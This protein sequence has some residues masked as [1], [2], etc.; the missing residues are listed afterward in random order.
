MSLSHFR[1]CHQEVYILD[2]EFFIIAMST[3]DTRWMNMLALPR[4]VRI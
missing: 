4:L 2:P 3:V 1:R